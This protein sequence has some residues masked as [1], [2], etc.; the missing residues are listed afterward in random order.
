[1]WS[2]HWVGGCLARHFWLFFVASG[3]ALLN[4][5]RHG[6]GG[7]ALTIAG[8]LRLFPFVFVGA[9][10]I[11]LIVN[12]I[13]ERRISVA[14]RRFL[15][16]AAIAFVVGVGA[17]GATVGFDS[18]SRFAHVFQRHSHSAM[19]NQFGLSTLLVWTAGED[20]PDMLDARL[21]NPFEKWETTLLRHRVERR[22]LWA[23]GVI[24]SLAVIVLSAAGG[25][26]AAECVALAGL[27][28]FSTLP[29]TSYDYTWVVVL[30]ALARS[31]P[32]VLPALLS[33]AVFTLLLFVVGGE[34]MG[35]QH[36]LGSIACLVML[37]MGVP[38]KELW[39]RALAAASLGPPL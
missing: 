16:G 12:A 32:V 7:A 28:L 21:T 17:A 11:W 23:V 5:E 1:M 27:L 3:V 37:A 9:A 8:L 36:V 24:V 19:T 29:M 4:R 39:E 13:R 22:P 10:G 33:F 26:S 25:A 20:P 15:A 14:G 18:Y 31:R 6:L 34:A 35:T 38:W 30:V 2:Y